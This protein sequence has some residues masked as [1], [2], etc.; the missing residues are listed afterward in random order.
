MKLWMNARTT[1]MLQVTGS[2]VLILF[3]VTAGGIYWMTRG[4]DNCWKQEAAQAFEKYGPHKTR[5][6]I[7]RVADTKNDYGSNPLEVIEKDPNGCSLGSNGVTVVRFSFDDR[8]KLMAIQVFRD[9]VA[10]PNF[11]MELIEERKF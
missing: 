3:I 4:E 7:L 5:S 10:A 8:N 1:K 9:Y 11:E 6:D 2:L